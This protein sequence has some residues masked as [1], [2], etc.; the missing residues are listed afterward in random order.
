VSVQ[1]S[2]REAKLIT[3]EQ[4][5][6]PKRFKEQTQDP[7]TEAVLRSLLDDIRRGEPKYEQILPSLASFLRQDLPTIQAD[8][9]RRGGVKSMVFKGV[10][11]RGSDIYQVTFENGNMEC[12]LMLASDG[13]IILLGFS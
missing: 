8:M 4:G 7:R 1:L 2:D 11:P 6:A 13:T 5:V 12:R 10:S 9:K 3:E